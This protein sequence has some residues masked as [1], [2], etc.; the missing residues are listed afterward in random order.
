VVED[1]PGTLEPQPEQISTTRQLDEGQQQ[2][3]ARDQNRESQAGSHGMDGIAEGGPKGGRE[4]AAISATQGVSD[5]NGHGGTRRDD[6]RGRERQ[7]GEE[8][9]V[10]SSGAS[11]RIGKQNRH[12]GAAAIP[13]TGRDTSTMQLDQMP[14]N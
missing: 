3:G 8:Q 2:R 5:Y 12:A 1:A 10:H 11:R 4:A 13:V 9:G 7:V 14:D 6:Q